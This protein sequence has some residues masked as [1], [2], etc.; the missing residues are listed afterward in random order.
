MNKNTTNFWLAAI[1]GTNVLLIVSS[2]AI[3]RENLSFN[4]LSFG[5]LGVHVACNSSMLWRWILMHVHGTD[6][7]LNVI[8]NWVIDLF[9]VPASAPQLV[10]Q[11]S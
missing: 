8:G 1:T 6:S 11:R 9:L 10:Y 4:F 3:C 5:I 2:A 7:S